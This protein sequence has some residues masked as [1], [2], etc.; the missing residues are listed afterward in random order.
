MASP[1]AVRRRSASSASS[2][3][4][5]LRRAMPSVL[6]PTAHSA[7]PTLRERRPPAPSGTRPCHR[8]S[9]RGSSL[10][11]GLEAVSRTLASAA[12]SLVA[13]CAAHSC[14]SLSGPRA[15][16]T[17]RRTSGRHAPRSALTTTAGTS[18]TPSA[19][20]TK[21]AASSSSTATRSASPPSSA[22]A[23]GTAAC[24]SRRRHAMSETPDLTA[25]AIAL[26]AGREPTFA[27]WAR[28][29]GQPPDSAEAASAAAGSSNSVEASS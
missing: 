26:G 11:S 24:S 18:R 2:P 8:R 3:A 15:A 28:R 25:L 9:D 5:S 21:P 6:R 16:A 23:S 19:V 17:A 20:V 14:L 4:I 29:S 22:V 13:S 1:R 10:S 7:F 12:R 27:T